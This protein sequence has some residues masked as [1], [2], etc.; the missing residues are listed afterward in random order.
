[1]QQKINCEKKEMT[2]LTF[3]ESRSY[4]N[5]K[6]CYICKKVFITDDNEEYHK[7]RVH[8]H[9]AGKY[10]EA[11]HNK[12]NRNYKIY[13]KNPV[14]FHGSSIYDYHFIFKKRAKEFDGQFE[15]LKEN[16]ENILLFLY[17]SIK[18]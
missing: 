3:E 17:Q 6:V 10:R 5:Q 15:C 1:M 7:V 4:K 11:A 18:T 14:V 9:F 2:P 13:K 16:T 8:C 12:C